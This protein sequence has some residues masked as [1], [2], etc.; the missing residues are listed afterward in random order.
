MSENDYILS[1]NQAINYIHD[2]IDKNLTVED[3]ANHC[4]FSKYYF[5]R[6]FRSIVK[7]SIYSLKYNPVD[8][9]QIRR[10]NIDEVNKYIA[11]QRHIIME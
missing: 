7:E 1:I 9:K 4:C 8:A 10:L 11:G 5:N 6:V 2:N 3:I